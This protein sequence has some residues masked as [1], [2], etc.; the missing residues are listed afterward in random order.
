MTSF[1]LYFTNLWCI[2]LFVVDPFCEKFVAV[3]IFMS[4]KTADGA[5]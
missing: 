3:L 4:H 2:L 1:R 5:I